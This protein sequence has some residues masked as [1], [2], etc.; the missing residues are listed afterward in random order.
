MDEPAVARSP[1]SE[2][3]TLREKP[4]YPTAFTRYPML[5]PGWCAAGALWKSKTLGRRE[6]ARHRYALGLDF[7]T[8]SVRAL[9][10]DV[11]NGR[12]AATSVW[13]YRHGEAGVIVDPED[14][15]LARQHP[16]DYLDGIVAVTKAALRAAKKSKGI[17]G[18]DIVGIGVDTTG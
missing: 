6:M 17:T 7:G 16:Q 15:D 11:A 13:N 8:S 9:I 10:V 4:L 14:P 2:S 5:S 3:R 12:E 18:A 1:V